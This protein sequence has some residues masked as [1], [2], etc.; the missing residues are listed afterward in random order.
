MHPAGLQF[1]RYKHLQANTRTLRYTG[2][3]W[4]VA[5]LFAIQ[6]LQGQKFLIL[7]WVFSVTSYF[8]P[9]ESKQVV[10]QIDPSFPYPS[11]F[12]PPSSQSDDIS[13]RF[14]QRISE[15][16]R[17]QRET[18]LYERQKRQNRQLHRSSSRQ[19][20]T[21]G[22]SS[23]QGNASQSRGK[24]LDKRGSCTSLDAFSNSGLTQRHRLSSASSPQLSAQSRRYHSSSSGSSQTSSNR[25]GKPKRQRP[26]KRRQ[27]IVQ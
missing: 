23:S 10:E 20:L 11:P 18:V 16:A 17:L 24:P 12:S 9:R 26:S 8:M 22:S 3:R 1:V 6:G 27:S 25:G 13:Q 5:Q 4:C 19:S 2:I 14:E 15:M 21:K 7:K